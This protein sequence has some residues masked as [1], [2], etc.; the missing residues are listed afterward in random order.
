MKIRIRCA[1]MNDN[2]LLA[3]VGRRLFATAFGAQNKPEDLAAYLAKSFSPQ[4]QADELAD[5]ASVTLIAESEG[6]FA[7]YARL[8][9]GQPVFAIPGQH[10]VE[11]VRIYSEREY[12]G[13]G[14]GSALMQACLEEAARREFDV[15]WLGVWEQNPRAIRFYERWGFVRAGTQIFKLGEDFQTDYVMYLKLPAP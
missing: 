2:E 8:K 12:I 3:E 13:Q 5:P 4:I 1:K 6:A 15:I 10:P 7:G 9:V 14:V 11:L